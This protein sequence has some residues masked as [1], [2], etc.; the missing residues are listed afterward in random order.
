MIIT[1]ANPAWGTQRKRRYESTGGADRK[2]KSLGLKLLEQ[3]TQT[4]LLA[5]GQF[6]PIMLKEIVYSLLLW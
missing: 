5:G 2:G 6:C 1:M 3:F 4:S